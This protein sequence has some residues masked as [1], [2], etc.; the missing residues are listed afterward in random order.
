[1]PGRSSNSE[2]FAG[3]CGPCRYI[4]R[5]ASGQCVLLNCSETGA[6]AGISIHSASCFRELAFARYRPANQ[7]TQ[8]VFQLLRAQPFLNRCRLRTPKNCDA[9][10]VA[11]LSTGPL[12]NAAH[13]KNRGGTSCA[14]DAAATFAERDFPDSA[15]CSLKQSSH[16]H[17]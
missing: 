9:N 7:F 16:C 12:G 10:Q 15:C 11:M 6:L 2:L 13:C 8:T 17:W 1:M 3:G 5:T 14:R 4:L